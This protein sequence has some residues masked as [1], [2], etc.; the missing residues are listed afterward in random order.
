MAPCLKAWFAEQ[1]ESGGFN[2]FLCVIK[3]CF[4]F[5]IFQ[6]MNTGKYIDVKKPHFFIYTN[7][8]DLNS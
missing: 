1:K 4:S 3:A 6:F 2:I 5:S 7:K 8:T